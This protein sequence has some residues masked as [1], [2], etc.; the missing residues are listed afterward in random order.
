MKSFDIKKFA[1]Q[2]KLGKGKIKSRKDAE[3]Y[4]KFGSNPNTL[5]LYFEVSDEALQYIL[6]QTAM[7]EIKQ[8]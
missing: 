6:A 7:D 5:L 4:I 2:I 8:N 1:E 3:D